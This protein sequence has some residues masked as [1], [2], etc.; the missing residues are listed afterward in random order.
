MENFYKLLSNSNSKNTF[1][2]LMNKMENYE[3]KINKTYKNFDKNDY[4][5]FF[6][7]YYSNLTSATICNAITMLRK[8][9]KY[10]NID[11]DFLNIKFLRNN[12]L[13]MK[14]QNYYSP[15]EIKEIVDSLL[16]AQ[17]KA[18]VMLTYIGFYDEDFKTLKNLRRSQIQ[19]DKIIFDDGTEFE[20]S[21]YLED[22][23]LDATLE[24]FNYK[25]NGELD[26]YDLNDSP[27]LFRGRA[28]KNKEVLSSVTLKKRFKMINDYL[29]L[30]NFTAIKVKHSGTLYELVKYEMKRKENLKRHDIRNFCVING[31]KAGIETL[32]T[33]LKEMR[34]KIQNDILSEKDNFIG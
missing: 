17:D 30:E 13:K 12:G 3:R 9:C 27:Y 15:S 16:N 5:N 23:L 34:E 26:T 10:E 11:L 21:S 4:L 1:A 24:E 20:V 2:T 6:L 32:E 31:V 19:F 14:K 22:I 18:L 7:E 28:S 25:Y 29:G 8:A 33:A